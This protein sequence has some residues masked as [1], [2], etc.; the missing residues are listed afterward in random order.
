MQAVKVDVPQ[1]QLLP[2][3]KQVPRHLPVEI[4]MSSQ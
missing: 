2:N 1:M 4:E 3:V